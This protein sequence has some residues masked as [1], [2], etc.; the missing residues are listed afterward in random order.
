MRL[1]VP[2]V[3]PVPTTRLPAAPEHSRRR[4]RGLSRVKPLPKCPECNQSFQSRAA[5]D[6]HARSHLG[7][8]P[9]A[10]TQCTQSFPC[11][12]DLEQHQKSHVTQVDPGTGPQS[13]SACAECGNSLGKS[14]DLR[15]HQHRHRGHFF[16]QKRRLVTRQRIRTGK[17]PFSAAR[18]S[19]AGAPAP[20]TTAATPSR[21]SHS[22]VDAAR[23]AA[24]GCTSER[25]G[26][27]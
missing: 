4:Q 22:V 25:T 6:V 1:G 15:Q 16:S 26:A 14:W 10:C 24:G 8:W 5:L 19:T 13:P 21:G 12:G 20:S 27:G 2:G 17:R 3:L 11:S 7:E 9:F 23:T 18:A